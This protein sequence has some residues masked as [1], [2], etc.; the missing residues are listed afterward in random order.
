VRGGRRS[1][2]LGDTRPERSHGT[3]W[4]SAQSPIEIER[5]ERT[6]C[7]ADRERERERR[8][9]KQVKSRGE[10]RDK[11]IMW[12][13]RHDGDFFGADVMFKISSTC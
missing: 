6:R 8:G 2:R 13:T 5:E 11:D 7:S 12:I 9:P 1:S 4:S 3:G 10:E